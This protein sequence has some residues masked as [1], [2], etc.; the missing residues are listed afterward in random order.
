MIGN[1]NFYHEEYIIKE[2]HKFERFTCMTLMDLSKLKLFYA[3]AQEGNVTK[4]A[5]KLNITQSALSKS[6]TDFEERIKTKLFERIPKGMRLTPQGERLYAHTKKL[7][8]EQEAFEK[9]F[10]EKEDEIEGEIKILTTPYVGTDWLIPH[11]KGFLKKHPKL[12]V[13]MLLCNEEIRS[14]Q[15][16]DIAICG[17]I[18]QQ[19]HLIHEQLFTLAIRLF[20]SQ[21]YL[22]E[23]G[24]PETPEDLD[25]HRLIYNEHQYMPY[26]NWLLNVG[27]T[28][29][30]PP[31]K[32]YLRIY[33]LHG[34]INAALQGLG[35]IEAPNLTSI[36]NLDLKE[37]LPNT[38]GSQ[39][40]YYFIFPENRKNSKKINHLLKYLAKKGK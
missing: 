5:E 11:L 39:V 12:T 13:E 22:D 37:V 1:A 32:P 33:S 23:F 31:R 18:P 36:L 26:G 8:E 16:C 21:T 19:P 20:S 4:A 38:P 34:L 7:I 28:A 24:I 2:L 30:I 14:L 9:V 15:D 35:I 10:Y 6:L 25:N 27:H 29:N 40:P 17:F 3:I